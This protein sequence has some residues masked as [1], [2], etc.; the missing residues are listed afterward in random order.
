MASSSAPGRA[1]FVIGPGFIGGEII[2]LLEAASAAFHKRGV[3]TVIGTLD[4]KVVIEEHVA[5][6]DVV[7]H[8]ATSRH[9]PSVEA[10]FA[11]IRRRAENSQETIYIHT[12]G[13]THLADNSAG[14]FKCDKIFD[15]DPRNKVDSAV[16]RGRQTV[17][18]QA[19]I[20]LVVPPVVYGI[21]E[22]SG[23]TSIQQPTLVRFSI[24]HG[25]AGQIGEGLS[26]W[27]HIH[28]KD[29]TRGYMVILHWMERAS[30]REVLANPFWFCENG[31]QL[32]WHE[33]AVAY[34]RAL[35]G[36]GYIP[37]S[38]V[39]KAIPPSDFCGL[40]GDYSEVAAGSN[41]RNKA[42]R[43]LKLGWEPAEKPTLASLVED[44]V[45]SI[46]KESGSFE[47]SKGLVAS[48]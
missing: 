34:G 45:P 24:K 4:D 28:V 5:V 13:A 32:S 21:S 6:S 9:L 33:C 1:V 47:G 30:A 3:K 11:G 41:S 44:E 42:S 40:F 15:D 2:A 20:S 23:R 46:L 7:I 38:P 18:P 39:P 16:L 43:L 27:S 29:L 36:M 35:H 17:G 48:S 37:D 31:Q 10:V 22:Q 19:K 14:S 26:V 8:A 25:Y 12:S